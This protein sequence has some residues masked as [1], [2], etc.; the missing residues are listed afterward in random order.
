[1]MSTSLRTPQKRDQ[2]RDQRRALLARASARRR[3]AGAAMFIVAVTLGLLAAMGVYGLA[4]TAQDVRA[5]GYGRQAVQSQ[6]AAA[7]A[8]NLTASVLSPGNAQRIMNDMMLDST[9]RDATV[10]KACTTAKPLTLTGTDGIRDRAAE[11]CLMLTPTSMKPYAQDSTN[12]IAPTGYTI[13]FSD[14]SFGKVQTFPNIRIELTNPIDWAAPAGFA[15][16]SGPGNPPPV[17]TQIR[18]TIFAEMR[19]AAVSG[20]LKPAESIAVGRGRL[21]VGPYLPL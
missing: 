19:P 14:E 8:V 9:L 4:A 17:F 20:K 12:M 21:V 5:A 16:S 7:L 13:P 3:S 6:H 1:M 18:V 10:R 2:K 15:L 11:A